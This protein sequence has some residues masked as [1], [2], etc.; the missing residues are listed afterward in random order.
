MSR[1]ARR[2]DTHEAPQAGGPAPAPGEEH[3]VA[4]RGSEVGGRD[5]GGRDE[6]GS[7]RRPLARPRRLALRPRDRLVSLLS[8]LAL[9]ADGWAWLPV[10]ERWRM[11]EDV[12]VFHRRWLAISA[13]YLTHSRS[14]GFDPATIAKLRA[15]PGESR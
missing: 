4:E 7:R 10:Y 15:W 5:E 1:S 3:R 2:R 13:H 9:R 11:G 14:E 6:V 12:S 8:T